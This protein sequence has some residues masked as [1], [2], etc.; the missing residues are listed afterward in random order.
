LIAML[1]V[2]FQ[3]DFPIVNQAPATVAVSL[4]IAMTLFVP[5]ERTERTD[6]RP[7]Q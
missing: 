1:F 5:D 7:G 2:A 4:L 6:A 3:L